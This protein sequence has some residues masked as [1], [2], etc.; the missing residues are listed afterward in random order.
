M[1]SRTLIKMKYMPEW[2]SRKRKAKSLSHGISRKVLDCD[3]TPS[4]MPIEQPKAL[5]HVRVP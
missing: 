3:L 2:V 1:S 4:M 5:Q